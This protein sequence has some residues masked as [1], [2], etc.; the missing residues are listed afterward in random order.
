[1]RR[2]RFHCIIGRGSYLHPAGDVYQFEM[3]I[4]AV[5]WV[6]VAS[7]VPDSTNAR[8]PRYGAV[9]AAW[10]WK[11]AWA[12]S[13]RPDRS[14]FTRTLSRWSGSRKYHWPAFVECSLAGYWRG[15]RSLRVESCRPISREIAYTRWRYKE[16]RH[17]PR[18]AGVLRPRAKRRDSRICAISA[19]KRRARSLRGSTRVS[20]W[21]WNFLDGKNHAG[22]YRDGFQLRNWKRAVASRGSSVCNKFLRAGWHIKTPVSSPDPRGRETERKKERAVFPNRHYSYDRDPEWDKQ[23]PVG[24]S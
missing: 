10:N 4:G 12:D 22:K 13:Y 14:T 21:A 2:H 11:L 17:S 6:R 16:C 3:N 5:S 9:P 24:V 15:W 19:K 23:S 18:F 8:Y 7:R 20:R 1:M